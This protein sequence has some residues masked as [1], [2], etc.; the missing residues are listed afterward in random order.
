MSQSQLSR[1]RLRNI[2]LSNAIILSIYAFITRKNTFIVHLRSHM[3]TLRVRDYIIFFLIP[4]GS[5]SFIVYRTKS[6]K[7]KD[8][9]WYSVYYIL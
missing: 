6:V 5:F 8:I 1:S 9:S 2:F 7:T 3:N 4:K